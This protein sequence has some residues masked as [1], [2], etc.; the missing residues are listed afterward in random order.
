MCV[1]VSGFVCML[2]KVKENE[3][4]REEVKTVSV[5]EREGEMFERFDH[6]TRPI[7]SFY[8]VLD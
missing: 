4:G 3:H 6:Y 2:G 7:L 5:C 8:S 1:S